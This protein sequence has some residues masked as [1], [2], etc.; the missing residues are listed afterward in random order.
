MGFINDKEY[1]D[2]GLPSGILWATTNVGAKS[3]TDAGDK[4]KWGEKQPADGSR[5]H[6]YYD[7]NEQKYTKYINCA[8][9]IKECDYLN[10]LLPE[11]DIATILWGKQWRYPSVED[12]HELDENCE[13]EV[14]DNYQESGI[15]GILG[16]S[17]LNGAS[18]FFPKDT[19]TSFFWCAETYSD[20]KAMDF[21]I[22]EN[23][24]GYGNFD[25]C[26]SHYIRPVIGFR[27]ISFKRYWCVNP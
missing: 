18:I 3:I 15:G 1:V 25:R 4:Y 6:I 5:G 21:D 7:E 13:W 24:L 8:E 12:A 17:K 26:D 27:R 9:D 23:G 14:V 20:I 2:L 11:D 22:T 19:D 16:T 10:V